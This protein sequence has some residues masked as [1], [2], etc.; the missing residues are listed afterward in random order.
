MA[1]LRRIRL[2]ITVRTRRKRRRG[3]LDLRGRLPV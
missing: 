1:M 3:Y 2:L